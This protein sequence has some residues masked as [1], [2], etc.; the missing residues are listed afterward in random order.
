MPLTLGL[1]NGTAKVVGFRRFGKALLAS[2]DVI[3]QQGDVLY[4]AVLSNDVA[5]LDAFLAKG[6]GERR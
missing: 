3:V 6:P 5:Q 4:I 2:D 1:V